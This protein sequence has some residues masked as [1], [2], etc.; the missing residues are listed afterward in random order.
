M[1]HL[2]VVAGSS[3]LQIFY[4]FIPPSQNADPGL[5]GLTITRLNCRDPSMTTPRLTSASSSE[6]RPW[7]WVSL[8]PSKT[9]HTP[10]PTYLE[11]TLHSASLPISMSIR[12]DYQAPVAFPPHRNALGPLSVM[13]HCERWALAVDFS[14]VK[15]S[16]RGGARRD[17]GQT[18]AARP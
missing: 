11:L 6:P 17:I 5:A 12:G 16:V 15:V 18:D 1:A 9:L 3:T 13:N 4:A 10:Y 8:P 7:H 2:G 14:G